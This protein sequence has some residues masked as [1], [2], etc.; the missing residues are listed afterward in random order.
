MTEHPEA[1]AGAARPPLRTAAVLVL[2]HPSLWVPAASGAARFAASGWWR[3]RPFLPTPDSRYWRF[4]ME[5]AYGD[6]LA[7]P[8]DDDMRAALLWARRARAPRR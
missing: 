8:D 7:S 5:T 2:R 6:E 3:R 4:R 1:P